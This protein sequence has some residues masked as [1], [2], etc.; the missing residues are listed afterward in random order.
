M[1]ARK[2]NRRVN[3]E[4]INFKTIRKVA[5]KV[6]KNLLLFWFMMMILAIILGYVYR[7]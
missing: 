4:N 7:I 6:F 5:W 3:M 1:I 2:N